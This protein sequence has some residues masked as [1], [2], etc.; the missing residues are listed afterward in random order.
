MNYMWVFSLG[1]VF[2]SYFF[3]PGG[4][5]SITLQ[6]DGNALQAVKAAQDVL[7]D[8]RVVFTEKSQRDKAAKTIKTAAAK[9]AAEPK[10][11]AGAKR[12]ANGKQADA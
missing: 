12:R 8:I 4:H 1:G 2:W 11:K 6:A 10:A 5:Q 3:L 9:A 7:K